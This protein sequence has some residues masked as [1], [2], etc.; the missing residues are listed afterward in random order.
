MRS[1]NISFIYFSIQELNHKF[2]D[3]PLF[4]SIHPNGIFICISFWNI[5]R[6]YVYT[7]NGLVLFKE[8]HI[9]NA[10]IVRIFK[11]LIEIQ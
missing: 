10:R 2:V 9:S 5:I 6:L 1:I 3:E 11:Y 4:L 8:L 7:I